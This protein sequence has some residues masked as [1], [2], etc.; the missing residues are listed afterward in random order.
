MASGGGQGGQGLRHNRRYSQRG[1]EWPEGTVDLVGAC[2]LPE[3]FGFDS[4]GDGK[5]STTE[6]GVIS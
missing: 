2:R 6:G 1:K 4:E 5:G 3:E